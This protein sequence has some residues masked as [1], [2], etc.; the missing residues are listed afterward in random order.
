M[1]AP[2]RPRRIFSFQE[3]SSLLWRRWSGGR[4][5]GECGQG[6][7]KRS[8]SSRCPHGPRDADRSAG[9]V[10]GFTAWRRVRSLRL[11]LNRRREAPR[12][13]YPAGPMAGAASLRNGLTG[14]QYVT[15]RAWRDARLERCP[16]H[17]RGG[18]SLARHG[19]YERK[20]PWVCGSLAGTARQSHTTF[21]L[22][23][24]CL[25]QHLLEIVDERGHRP[26]RGGAD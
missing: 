25:K 20:T 8:L 23:P 12:G 15:A 14:E 5:I 1:W 7:G 18:C 24:N 6:V 22:L 16:N 26:S 9:R 3:S 2:W 11:R 21:S 4:E 17:P 13:P 19:T 10:H